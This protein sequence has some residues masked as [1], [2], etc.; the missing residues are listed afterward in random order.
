[1]ERYGEGIGI[2]LEQL[3]KPKTIDE[4]LN[5]GFEKGVFNTFFSYQRASLMYMPIT[6]PDIHKYLDK[7]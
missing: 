3:E 7:N 5:G 1:M 2:K 6:H 4:L